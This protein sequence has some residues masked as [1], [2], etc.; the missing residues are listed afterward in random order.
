MCRRRSVSS[1]N[2][3]RTTGRGRFLAQACDAFV[4][5]SAKWLTL[6]FSAD[7]HSW[8]K[9]ITHA[10][11]PISGWPSEENVSLCFVG[12]ERGYLVDATGKRSHDNRCE[13]KADVE[14]IIANVA[15]CFWANPR[16]TVTIWGNLTC[17]YRLFLKFL[18][19]RYIVW[20]IKFLFMK[21]AWWHFKIW[22]VIC[23]TADDR[24][25]LGDNRYSVV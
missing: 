14:Y 11:C 21:C 6:I 3:S 19:T 15:D 16:W 17:Y 18:Y 1:K 5:T 2:K 7:N 13:I 20:R 23:G 12:L 9:S 8:T 4:A 25:M 24:A 10:E 22:N